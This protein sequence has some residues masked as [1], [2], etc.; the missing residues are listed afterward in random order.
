MHTGLKIFCIF[1]IAYSKVGAIQYCNNSS[2]IG[3]EKWCK[4]TYFTCST[5]RV[6]TTLPGGNPVLLIQNDLLMRT[7]QNILHGKKYSNAK[8]NAQHSDIVHL[9]KDILFIQGSKSINEDLH[10]LLHAFITHPDFKDYTPKGISDL[11]FSIK[12]VTNFFFDAELKIKT[13][14]V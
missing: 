11:L 10:M 9:V 5:S 14:Y 4:S 12:T 8:A 3:S 7:K 13:Q 6:R 2:N 1:A